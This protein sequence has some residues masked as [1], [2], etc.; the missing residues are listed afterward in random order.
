M[1]LKNRISF[2][3]SLLF[4]VLFGVSAIVTYI[5]F[6]D[7][8]K[9]EFEDRLKVKA[10]ASIRLLVEVEQVDNQL[11]KIIDKN[12]INK[13]YNEKTL[14]F[15]A[16]YNLIYSSLD[17]TKIQWTNDDLKFLKR[18]KTFFKKENEQ[19]IYGV[20]YDTNQED[21]YALISASDNYGNRK[22]TYLAYI[23]VF[24]YIIFTA[25]SWLITYAVVKKRLSPI[26]DF[27]KKIKSINE[28]NLETRVEVNKGKKD[29]IDL[30]ATEFNKMLKRISQSYKKQKE[31]TSNASHELRTPISRLTAQLENRIIAE[32]KEGNFNDFN[33][34]LLQD[35]NQLS[36][37]T[38]S[39]LLLSQLDSDFNQYQELCR[40]DELIFDSAEKINTQ[41]PDFKLDL[42]FLEV[43]VLEIKGNKSLLTIAFSNLLKN[44]YLY[45]ESK[46]VHVSIESV[47]NKL[48]VLIM[49]DGHLISQEEIKKIFQPFMRGKNAKNNKNGLGLGLRIV[50]RVFNQ[51]NAVI[52]YT[53]SK[54]KLN[55]FKI[56]FDC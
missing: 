1:N 15:D 39:L 13:L 5:L 21:Y 34:T 53:I 49:N 26:N 33:K 9:D 6:A 24:S 28:N 47:A 41:F 55:T 52:T 45:S 54:N 2:N 43:N 50:Q 29:E 30:L 14:I 27:H 18:N 38:S 32:N 10:L 16:N 3:V 12:S 51:H 44:A 42:E 7:F 40:I 56:Q 4:T 31:F 36:E 48:N 37:L 17:D 11:L 19:E 46:Q 22:L 25:V 35:I 23:L 8:R 20:F